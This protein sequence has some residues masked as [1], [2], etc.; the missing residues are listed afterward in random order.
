MCGRGSCQVRGRVLKIIM[1]VHKQRFQMDVGMSSILLQAYKA[2]KQ[3]ET[4]VVA[5]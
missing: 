4:L 2:H 3:E 5:A 1:K